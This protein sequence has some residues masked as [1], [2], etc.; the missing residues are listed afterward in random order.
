MNTKPV[1]QQL[2]DVLAYIATDDD[3]VINADYFD[4]KSQKYRTYY[5]S[6]R[7]KLEKDGY[8]FVEKINEYNITAYQTIEGKLFYEAGG[9]TSQ[10]VRDDL[11]IT[12]N[13]QA[14]KKTQTNELRVVWGTWFAGLIGLLVLAWSVWLWFY[15]TLSAFKKAC[16]K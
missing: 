4:K 1:T 8:I 13:A 7:N 16:L 10:K 6:L 11:L 12:Q 14:L 9:Y 15:P 5:L 2:D 3:S